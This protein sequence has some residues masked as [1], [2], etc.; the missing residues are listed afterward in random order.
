MRCFVYEYMTATGL[1]REPGSPEHAMYL[2]GRA[3]R[4]ALAEEPGQ[5]GREELHDRSSSKL[6]SDC[7]EAP[8]R[9]R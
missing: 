7:R 8:R 6:E 1:G 2:E 3:M 5:G 4:D 9:A